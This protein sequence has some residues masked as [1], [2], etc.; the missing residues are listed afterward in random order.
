MSLLVKNKANSLDGGQ[1]KTS[2]T[3]GGSE[4]LLISIRFINA[5]DIH[6]NT[7][8]FW[9]GFSQRP[10]TE[11]KERIRQLLIISLL[12]YSHKN[13]SS[14]C[15]FIARI[16]IEWFFFF[17]LLC[18]LFYPFISHIFSHY[19]TSHQGP[20]S[21]KRS[22]LFFWRILIHPSDTNLLILFNKRISLFIL[23]PSL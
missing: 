3:L 10:G 22:I 1:L 19:E 6:I 13:C 23:W 5:Y 21:Y 7:A 8:S 18:L 4:S 2:L 20:A 12:S 17:F 15:M 11:N 16:G 9:S 14:N